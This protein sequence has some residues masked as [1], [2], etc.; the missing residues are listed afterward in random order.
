MS[1]HLLIIKFEI[2]NVTVVI[3]VEE[4]MYL[5]SLAKYVEYPEAKIWFLGPY[6]C[7]HDIIS[8]T[9]SLIRNALWAKERDRSSEREKGF[10]YVSEKYLIRQ[11]HCYMRN[12]QS[13]S[14][15]IPEHYLPS[16][17]Q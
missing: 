7:A 6:S 10:W 3:D 13:D 8:V 12:T 5:F 2:I 4:F 14:H 11:L 9:V 17:I 16:H 1:K 15:A